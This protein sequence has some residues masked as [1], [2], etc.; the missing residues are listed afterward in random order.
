VVQD[1]IAVI[2]EPTMNVHVFPVIELNAPPNIP[3]AVESDDI[4]LLQPPPTVELLPDAVLQKPPLT[5]EVLPDAILQ[6]PPLTVE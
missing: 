1:A 4:I 5:V 3:E 2:Q 6:K